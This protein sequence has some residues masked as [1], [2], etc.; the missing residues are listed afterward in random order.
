VFEL[1]FK[2]KYTCTSKVGSWAPVLADH[3][4]KQN[5]EILG[6]SR[7]I[8]KSDQ[9]EMLE[10]SCGQISSKIST[11]F[12]LGARDSGNLIGNVII[13]VAKKGK[14]REIHFSYFSRIISYFL[15]EETLHV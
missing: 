14:I 13:K 12:G 1:H 4:L 11:K 8:T 7:T 5:C 10:R 2:Q 3:R 9:I 6:Y 15:A